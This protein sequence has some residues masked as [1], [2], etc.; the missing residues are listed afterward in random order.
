[1]E[2]I[3]QLSSVGHQPS[4]IDSHHEPRA[5]RRVYFTS[6]GIYVD[7][8][9]AVDNTLRGLEKFVREMDF[10]THFHRSLKGRGT[11]SYFADLILSYLR[12]DVFLA[13]YPSFR[14]F[15]PFEKTW[16]TADR[17]L[18]RLLHALRRRPGAIL[19]V[20]DL[21][22]DQAISRGN[23]AQV[24][25]EA[26]RVERDVFGSFD[27][28]LVFNEAM[29]SLIS[30]RYRIE[31]GRF[32]EFEILDHITDFVPSPER[33][34]IKDK[35]TITYA[36]NYAEE[37]VG[38]WAERLPRSDAIRYAFIGTNWNWISVL[39][40]PDFQIIESLPDKPLVE[41]LSQNAAFGIIHAPAD[42]IEYYRLSSTS[43]MGT[44]LAAGLPI[45]AWSKLSY[46]SS[47]ISKYGVGIQYDH[48]EEVADLIEHITLS[49]Y[50]KM[51]ANCLAL[52]EKV[53][54]GFFFKT[55]MDR[56]MRALNS[57]G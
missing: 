49:D 17:R 37:K 33:K 3:S 31:P 10:E 23:V 6:P 43:K 18:L 1:M 8:L 35:W 30:Q 15:H 56:S 42:W 51:R 47:L 50:D 44:Y 38:R 22:I 40:R 32:V 34:A 25:D 46:V 28:L 53:R 2:N 5:L 13:A 4:G 36:G 16:R 55:A 27:K 21:P 24:D 45:L 29:A 20:Y 26:Y 39:G 48:L 14:N 52:G 19:Y 7:G 57:L 41:W 11:L 12:A 9:P 54:S